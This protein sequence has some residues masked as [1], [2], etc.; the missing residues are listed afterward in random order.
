MGLKY[1]NC[2]LLAN[3]LLLRSVSAVFSAT[4][5]ADGESCDKSPATGTVSYPHVWLIQNL[6]PITVSIGQRRTA[7]ETIFPHR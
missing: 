6:W 1:V 4:A 5:F 2:V 7:Y 3:D